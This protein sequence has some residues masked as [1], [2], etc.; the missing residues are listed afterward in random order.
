MIEQEPGEGL[1]LLEVGE[2][3]GALEHAQ[4]RARDATRGS[5]RPARAAWPDPRC[6]RARASACGSPASVVAGIPVGE[7]LAAARVA[8]AL[9]RDHHLAV[10]AHER[11]RVA[12]RARREPQREHGVGDRLDAAAR[13]VAARA[14]QF[15]R[16]PEA[17]RGA[18]QHEPVDPLGLVHREPHADG[19]AEREPAERDALEP[20]L[21][22]RSR[23]R[24]A[25]APRP[26][27]RACRRGR[28]RGP[29]WS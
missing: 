9:G 24:R 2:V 28:R 3:P 10:G 17:R 22:E 16:M 12:V 26:T 1:G 13:T 5:P 21:V 7:R 29:G 6:R 20:A 8:L 4:P 27:A 14:S 25:R 18:G 19:A 23:A 11:G 15:S